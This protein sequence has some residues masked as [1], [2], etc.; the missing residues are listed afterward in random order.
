MV[1]KCDA[2]TETISFEYNASETLSI[3]IDVDF[4][5]S[6]TVVCSTQSD[7][8]ENDTESTDTQKWFEGRRIVELSVI[9]DALKKVVVCVKCP[10]P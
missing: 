6:E 5:I 10:C 9:V 4:D 2:Q 3:D 8:E 1:E 7:A